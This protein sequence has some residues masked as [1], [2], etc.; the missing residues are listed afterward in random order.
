MA[1]SGSINFLSASEYG[2]YLSSNRR[3]T[4]GILSVTGQGQ[5]GFIPT[6]FVGLNLNILDPVDS[7][8]NQLGGSGSSGI[9]DMIDSM[10]PALIGNPSTTYRSPL[11]P[12]NG[13]PPQIR[14]VD[15]T[16][17][18]TL[19]LN[20][21]GPY[22]HPSWKQIRGGDHPVARHL[23]MHNTMSVDLNNHNP[24]ETERKKKVFRDKIEDM[25]ARQ[26]AEFFHDEDV[27][28][29]D[30]TNPKGFQKHFR[31]QSLKQYYFPVLT[32][33]HKPV[34]YTVN[35]G[36]N[37]YK[38]RFSLMNHT[39]DFSAEAMNDELKYAS[40]DLLT[41]SNQKVDFV[42]TNTQVYDLLRMAKNTNGK[43]FIY[44]ERLYPRE[45][46][47]YR[48]FKLQRSSYE[49]VSG[50][51]N[52]GYDVT[53]PRL[54]WKTS[55]GGGTSLATSDGTT[56]LRS[57]GQALNSIG[58]QQNT[59]FPESYSAANTSSARQLISGSHNFVSAA[60]HL[61]NLQT[62]S[63]S[64]N[65]TTNSFD[66][67]LK[68]LLVEYINN[69]VVVNRF[70]TDGTHLPLPGDATH[71]AAAFYQLDSYQPYQISL[72][73][74][75]PLD[76]RNDIY[77]K[78]AYLT[79]S[80]GGKGLQI[81][82]TP[83]VSGTTAFAATSHPGYLQISGSSPYTTSSIIS[84]VSTLQTA[85]AGELVYSTKPTI[86]FWRNTNTH[87]TSSMSF[88]VAAATTVN[89]LFQEDISSSGVPK[90][91][92]ELQDAQGNR[93]GFAFRS[94]TTTA[95]GST[96]VATGSTFVEVGI[97]GLTPSSA[98]HVTTLLRRV[99]SAVNS[100]NS[101]A[102]GLSLNISASYETG[103]SS[104]KVL[105]FH[106]KT[107]GT[108]Q[109]IRTVTSSGP[110]DIQI[111]SPKHQL[112]NITIYAG[113]RAGGS[114]DTATQFKGPG[115]GTVTSLKDDAIMG[116]KTPT[117]S[118]QYNR[119]TFPYNTPFYVTNRVRGREPFFN[120]YSDFIGD[121]IELLGRDYTIFPEY[122]FSENFDYYLNN[123]SNM[124]NRN[125][126][127]YVINASSVVDTAE[128]NFQNG[129]IV[130]N[131]TVDGIVFPQDGPGFK[132]NSIEVLGV[133]TSAS[134]GI[135]KITKS[136]TRYKYDDI[137]G[138]QLTTNGPNIR[139]FKSDR[140]SVDFDNKYG[141]T[142]ST[143]NFASLLSLP[144]GDA[145][146]DG[147]NTI[148]TTLKFNCE[149][150]KKLLPYNGFYP[151]TRTTKI[152][153]VF[154]R[155]TGASG[156]NGKMDATPAG[157]TQQNS[158]TGPAYLQAF[159]EPF[160]APGILFNSIKSGIAVGYPIYTQ[161]PKY[162]FDRDYVNS[163][164]GATHG[165]NEDV[166]ET[167]WHGGLYMM[168]ASRCIPSILTSKPDK[169][170]P[171]KTLHDPQEFRNQLCLPNT[172][173][174]KGEIANRPYV[175]LVSDFIDLD[176]ASDKSTTATA[177]GRLRSGSIEIGNPHTQAP[178]KNGFDAFAKGGYFPTVN[179]FLS[180]MMEFF[181]ASDSETKTKLP[182]FVAGA[183]GQALQL[184]ED[185][186]Y[187]VELALY[188][189]KHQVMCEGPRNAGIGNRSG[190]LERT[191]ADSGY[192]IRNSFMRGYIYGP[193]T[194]IIPMPPG[195]KLNFEW[196]N[197]V[198]DFK[199]CIADFGD[200]DVYLAA[201]LQD[202]AYHAYTPPYFYGRSSCVYE[203]TQDTDLDMDISNIR[204]KFLSSDQG[205]TFFADEYTKPT[206]GSIAT[207]RFIVDDTS[208]LVSLP[209]TGSISNGS[210]LRMHIDKSINIKGE[211]FSIDPAQGIQSGK[212]V[213]AL[214][215]EWVCPVLDFSSSYSAVRNETRLY[216]TNNQI[217][218]IITDIGTV[219]NTFHDL[220]TG[221]GM[222]GGYGTDPYDQQLIH[223]VYEAEGIK[224]EEVD[225]DY[226]GDVKGIYLKINDF[227]I[228][229]NG[230][231]DTPAN[232]VFLTNPG[233]TDD[234]S[235]NVF[236][237][238]V[239]STTINSVDKIT[240]KLG[241]S[242]EPKPIGKFADSKE[243]S[244]GIVLIPYLDRKI[245]IKLKNT[246]AI[247][248]TGH[249]S[250]NIYETREI[251]P[252]KHFLPIHSGLFTNIMSV[253]VQDQ[254]LSQK[255]QEQKNLYM[256][257][258]HPFSQKVAEAIN[259]DSPLNYLSAAREEIKTTDVYKMIEKL[260]AYSDDSFVLP[261]EF[262]FVHNSNIPPFQAM[263]IP[264]SETLSK[265][266][267]IDIYQG[268]MPNSS[269][270]LE[271]VQQSISVHPNK[272]LE[273]FEVYMP[274]TTTVPAVLGSPGFDPAFEEDDPSDVDPS[275]VTST[276]TTSISKLFNSLGFANM[277]SPAGALEVNLN[278]Q[279]KPNESIFPFQTA[280]EFYKN[281][282]FMVFKVKKRAKKN[283]AN[284]RKSQIIKACDSA[285]SKN[286]RPPLD[287]AVSS[288]DNTTVER[289]KLKTN[290]DV[291]G[292]NWPYDYFSLLQ[293]GK[294][295]I[296]FEVNE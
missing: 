9:S 237:S 273:F 277:L 49:Q 270:F 292:P 124:T 193:P 132:A 67:G 129:K 48:D 164:H 53:F 238:T 227:N 216:E 185:Q 267:L 58:I 226:K 252:G 171:F 131:S 97:D 223:A 240:G 18:N 80:I 70:Q 2:S 14:F 143:S 36:Q 115:N 62:S 31:P 85:S 4:P 232:T 233:T 46:N 189:G 210:S 15:S 166:L 167:T 203:F 220:T 207:H 117:A 241:F 255:Q 256:T 39:M 169:I 228:S 10:T 174:S 178:V 150:F 211:L 66:L 286:A 272:K 123:Y 280:R 21:N 145:F 254:L 163:T 239:D 152:G 191:G 206:S 74:S 50:L 234:I 106:Q 114:T 294:I 104:E 244:E 112:R 130:R 262:D 279:F 120:S 188:A 82:L 25:N 253:Y 170:L 179:N 181:L 214:A 44:S 212:S 276:I 136:T 90:E 20:R 278:N 37:N 135:E 158:T 213:W 41:G 68:G 51:G 209:N 153:Q 184:S 225:P 247:L 259:V 281:L 265:Q 128:D 230:A 94:G 11:D 87:S 17:F 198:A 69:G 261:P 156:Y 243:I 296:E 183:N 242:T 75:W 105:V 111:T 168:G 229:S 219:Q 83:H 52:N 194:E 102:N 283:Y 8:N 109:A 251:I 160:M 19:M 146:E 224:R 258:E 147:E 204:N 190:A 78:P 84:A 176:R 200:Q 205:T 199:H 81:G 45:I 196:S 73:S 144:A 119:H 24:V 86:F 100:T 177:P 99:E 151:A 79:S 126:L 162:F 208:L 133:Q 293:T 157:Q 249:D 16:I 57:D 159:L 118:L 269:L 76:A 127:L 95:D 263:I 192:F 47:S 107:F 282:R 26:E 28:I 187:S 1:L 29:V 22:Q 248:G 55:Q 65:V 195:V 154:S 173:P 161:K 284:Y 89:E 260:S 12:V 288:E 54:F 275:A 98:A 236:Y 180:E 250:K 103:P 202:P 291:Y 33:K 59:V 264:F 64:K 235:D 245:S 215:P 93:V 110:A 125:D 116:Y 27:Y 43:R 40:G 246:F 175:H 218:E 113:N 149:A 221:R 287:F 72:L 137:Q 30:A 289:I 290:S 63:Y 32:T 7:S 91:K 231:S 6:D 13:Q 155:I 71:V 23:R 274:G 197:E 35:A 285:L 201:N 172:D 186:K 121:D 61:H 142:D 108:G 134:A 77:S 88:A 122:R 266:D 138:A 38:V 139:T 60:Y 165:V 141:I 222:W 268:I 182:V 101:A 92:F 217:A 140:D 148:P 3:M 5:A 257:N 34:V 42:R 295:D 96:F 56:R 271:K